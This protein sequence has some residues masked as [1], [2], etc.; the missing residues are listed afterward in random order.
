MKS[1][2]EMIEQFKSLFGN[3]ELSV[4]RYQGNYTDFF[5]E[6]S[7]IRVKCSFKECMEDL[8]SVVTEKNESE[9]RHESK[10]V[11]LFGNLAQ[12]QF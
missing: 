7:C 8:K 2:I 9:Y 6:S 3:F 10:I 5:I 12:S 1:T 4:F 11:A